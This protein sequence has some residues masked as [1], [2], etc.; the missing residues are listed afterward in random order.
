MIDSAGEG[1]EY[2]ANELRIYDTRQSNF[3][4]FVQCMR[5][6]YGDLKVWFIDRNSVHAVQRER[7]LI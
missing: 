7:A 5:R 2:A 4:L 1:E 3:R 6:E